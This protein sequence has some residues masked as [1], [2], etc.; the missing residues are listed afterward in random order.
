MVLLETVEDA[1][2]LPALLMPVLWRAGTRARPQVL[3][4]GVCT[5]AVEWT[6]PW[7]DLWG[8]SHFCAG[9]LPRGTVATGCVVYLLLCCRS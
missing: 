9:L 1:E 4:D 7:G 6:L 3:P 5:A 8:K 2:M